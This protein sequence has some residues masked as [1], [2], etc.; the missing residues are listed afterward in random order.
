MDDSPVLV[1]F[2]ITK[3]LN[4]DTLKQY[5]LQARAQASERGATTL[6]RGT[7]PV[8]GDPPFG[9]LL[10]QKWPTERAFREWQDSEAYRPLKALRDQ[11]VDIRI[12]VVPTV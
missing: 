7:S 10:V 5:Q 9:M 12:A 1:V 2:E 6:G 4:A 11:S 8:K 3:V